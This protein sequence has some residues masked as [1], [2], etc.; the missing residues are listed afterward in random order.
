MNPLMFTS[1]K[2]CRHAALSDKI[3]SKMVICTSNE[4]DV[5]SMP[6]RLRQIFSSIWAA[7]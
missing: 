2:R 1:D 6:I 7:V 5:D 4:T 3:S